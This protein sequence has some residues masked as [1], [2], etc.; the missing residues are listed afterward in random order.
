MPSIEEVID[1]ILPFA[2]WGF[3]TFPIISIYVTFVHYRWWRIYR[4]SPLIRHLLISSIAVDISALLVAFI[5]ANAYGYIPIDMPQ[6]GNTII[7]AIGLGIALSVK[8]YRRISLRALDD[9]GVDVQERVETQ[10]QRE[11]RQFGEERRKL[12]QEHNAD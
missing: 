3:L 11:D 8:V 1:I 2:E 4:P 10:D 9:P 5:V 6:G 12:E 7:L